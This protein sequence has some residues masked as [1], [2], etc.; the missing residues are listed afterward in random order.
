MHI[1]WYIFYIICRRTQSL[2]SWKYATAF[3]LRLCILSDK[4]AH[5]PRIM[6]VKIH[7]LWEL[8]YIWRY[9]E[10][11]KA[12]ERN[13]AFQLLLHCDPHTG[14]Y[15]WEERHT[16]NSLLVDPFCEVFLFILTC[17]D[18]PISI[19]IRYCLNI[20]RGQSLKALQLQKI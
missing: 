20:N 9:F 19:T 18:F 15:N 1:I 14:C 2:I 11:R 3:N 16:S 13:D 4:Y 12:V 17:K 5:I 6:C 10:R 8:K 7:A